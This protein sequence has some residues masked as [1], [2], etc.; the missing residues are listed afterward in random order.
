M[1]AAGEQ[2]AAPANRRLLFGLGLW[3]AAAAFVLFISVCA[4]FYDY[5]PAD[6]RIAHAIQGIDVPAFGGFMHFLNVIGDTKGYIVMVLGFTVALAVV[7]AG[8]ESIIMLFTIVPATFGHLLKAW[9]DRPRPSALLVHV[10]GHE[11]EFSFPS[12]HVIGIAAIFG[13][14]L[15]FMPAVVPWRPARWALM[16]VCLVFVAGI[17]PARIYIG[18]HWPSDTLASYLLTFLFM[19]PPLAVYT[20]F[21]GRPGPESGT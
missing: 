3:L 17:A 5:F 1:T 2:Q 8:W 19:A 14:L 9:V 18:V 6:L 7:R 4:A 11:A 20:R 15:F 16:A 10:S 12:G 21:R 13:A